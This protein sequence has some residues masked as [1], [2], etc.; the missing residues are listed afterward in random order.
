MIEHMSSSLPGSITRISSRVIGLPPSACMYKDDRKA[1]RFRLTPLAH[2]PRR[3][4]DLPVRPL[5]RSGN[6]VRDRSPERRTRNCRIRCQPNRDTACHNGTAICA[7]FVGQAVR[8]CLSFLLTIK[9]RQVVVW[10][11]YV[12]IGRVFC[13][14][15]PGFY[16]NDV[17]VVGLYRLVCKGHGFVVRVLDVGAL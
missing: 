13:V 5:P 6:L 2:Q 12:V 8:R 1:D 17:F 15:W 9:Q 7:W 14:Y 4:L 16:L 10:E 3:Q 11:V